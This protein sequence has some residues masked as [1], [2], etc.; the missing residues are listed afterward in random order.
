MPHKS[1]GIY[2]KYSKLQLDMAVS[3]VRSGKLNLRAASKHY[4][5]PRSTI[6]DRITGKISPGSVPG[7]A[8]AVPVHI[9]RLVTEKLMTI[10]DRGFGISRQNLLLKIGSI[11]G[12]LKIK[13]PFKDGIP[14]AWF[15]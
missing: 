1:K 14:C 6:S 5:V 11:C 15:L 4:K 8:P 13:T 2:C 10:S 9:E 12:Q 7:T 3:M